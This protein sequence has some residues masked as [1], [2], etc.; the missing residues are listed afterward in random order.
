V[1]EGN[2]LFTDLLLGPQSQQPARQCGDLL[3]RDR[4]DNWTYQF[5]VTVNDL[6]QG[7]DLVIRGEDLL[8][9]TGRQLQL[10]RFLGRPKPPVFL[11]HPLICRP[12]RTKLSKANRDSGIREL[13]DSGMSP[14]AVLGLAAFRG[15]LIEAVRD[16]AAGELHRL[17][18][19]QK[20]RFSRAFSLE[21]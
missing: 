16:L 15:G 18:L 5:A 2:E 6:D 4:A 20:T 1:E 8:A 19:P 14:S 10:A 13:R 17:F 21:P 12:D 3:V 7:I 9:S 11:H